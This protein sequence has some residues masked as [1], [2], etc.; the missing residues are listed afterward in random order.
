MTKQ[1]TK[2]KSA[3]T[4][5]CMPYCGPC[6]GGGEK[7]DGSGLSIPLKTTRKRDQPPPVP[8]FSGTWKLDVERSD[9]PEKLM[10]AQGLSYAARKAGSSLFSFNKVTHEI[11]HNTR[12]NRMIIEVT[13]RIKKSPIELVL[14]GTPHVIE[15]EEAGWIRATCKWNGKVLE[16]VGSGELGTLKVMR[17]LDNFEWMKVV[18]DFTNTQGVTG[19]MTRYFQKIEDNWS[20]T[21]RPTGANFSAPAKAAVEP[22][23]AAVEPVLVRTAAAAPKKEEELEFYPKE[24]EASVAAYEAGGFNQIPVHYTAQSYSVHPG[25]NWIPPST[26]RLSIPYSPYMNTTGSYYVNDIPQGALHTMPGPQASHYGPDIQQG[27][28]HTMPGPQASHYGPDIS[29]S[30]S[31]PGPSISHFGPDIYP[32]G[33]N[34]PQYLN[35]GHSIQQRPPQ[36]YILN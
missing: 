27:A 2:K 16:L 29:N 24:L 8:D 17:S 23:R 20:P 35:T 19:T 4:D 1:V 36:S 6:C 14:D 12:A 33:P 25:V 28:L 26:A 34:P 3:C 9:N 31:L 11:Y 10:E 15:S 13:S 21:P 30:V 18:T 32:S 5:A 22:A 7:K